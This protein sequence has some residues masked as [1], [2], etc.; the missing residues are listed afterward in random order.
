MEKMK[1]DKAHQAKTSTKSSAVKVVISWLIE[2]D[3]EF[4]VAQ[5]MVNETHDKL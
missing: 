2:T 4:R 5:S 3:R 1:Q